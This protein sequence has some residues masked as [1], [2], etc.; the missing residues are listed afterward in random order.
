MQTTDE[1]LAKKKIIISVRRVQGRSRTLFS[2]LFFTCLECTRGFSSLTCASLSTTTTGSK[3]TET[4]GLRS[5]RT[6]VN[7]IVGFSERGG[8]NFSFLHTSLLCEANYMPSSAYCFVSNL[9]FCL[10][11]KFKILSR[12]LEF[13]DSERVEK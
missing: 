8:R 7:H 2:L 12:S 3:I 1:L 6:I 13:V 10:H 9:C 5:A 11:E 4:L